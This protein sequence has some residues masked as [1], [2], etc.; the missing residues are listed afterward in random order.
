M[1]WNRAYDVSEISSSEIREAL[2]KNA[3]NSGPGANEVE[4]LFICSD[5][6]LR[7][8]LIALFRLEIE[9]DAKKGDHFAM[10]EIN[11]AS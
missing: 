5:S 3:A 9:A 10:K 2:A 6:G 4:K 11:N 1:K 7:K 8:A